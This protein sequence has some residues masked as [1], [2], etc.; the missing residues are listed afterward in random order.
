MSSMN[1]ATQRFRAVFCEASPSIGMFFLAVFFLG[2]NQGIMNSTF[3]NYLH[4]MFSITASQR[5]FVEFPREFPGFAIALVTGL[6]AAFSMRAWAILVGVFSLFGVIGLGFFSPSITFMVSWMVVWSLADHLFMPIESGMG[7][8]LAKDGGAGK[9]LG[10]IG[11]MRNLAMIV[12]TGTVAI[13]MGGMFHFGY[14]TLYSIAGFAAICS[15]LA[16]SR[17]RLPEDRGGV[18]RAFVYRKRYN[19]F[20][21]LCMIWGA[22]KQVFLTFAP[23][24]LVSRY[25]VTPSTMASLFL[26]AAALGVVFRQAFGVMV[27]RLGERFVLSL[28]SAMM[29][30]IC[31]GFAFSANVTLLCSLFVIDNLMFATRIARTTYLARIAKQKSDLPA[32][33]SLGVTADHMVSMTIPAVGGMLWNAAGSSMV[34]IAAAGVAVVGFFAARRIPL[35][36]V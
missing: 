1:W 31:L 35:R 33:L 4:D 36:N 21:F 14:K 10:Q 19:L 25:G 16:F 11:G 32:T 18:N 5:G 13:L 2:V 9:R 30:C 8:L 34:F 6:L 22:R 15:I 28:D 17:V 12:G 24:L 27:D 29:L 3:N 20:Y 23:W 7:L 26:I